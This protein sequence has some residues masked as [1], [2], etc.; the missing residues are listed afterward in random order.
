VIIVFVSDPLCRRDDGASS[1]EDL[2]EERLEM[3]AVSLAS[4]QVEHRQVIRFDPRRRRVRVQQVR[5]CT[6]SSPWAQPVFRRAEKIL[7]ADSCQTVC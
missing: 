4:P 6:A 3:S 1:G 5:L 7:P 2:N